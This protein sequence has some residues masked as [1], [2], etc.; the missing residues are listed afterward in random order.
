MSNPYSV[1]VMKSQQT[2]A[3]GGDSCTSSFE[4]AFEIV[5]W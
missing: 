5:V 4:V 3:I 1:E 2:R